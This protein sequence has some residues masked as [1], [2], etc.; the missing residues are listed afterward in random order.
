MG[1]DR[2][3]VE[4]LRAMATFSNL[5]DFKLQFS[6]IA[7]ELEALRAKLAA[8]QRMGTLSLVLPSDRVPRTDDHAINRPAT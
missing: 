4:W 8:T 1:A 2:D 6:R 5:S 3:A 7:D